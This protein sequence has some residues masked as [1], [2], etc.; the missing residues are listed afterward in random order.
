MQ[1]GAILPKGRRA[2]HSCIPIGTVK[3]PLTQPKLRLSVC[4]KNLDDVVSTSVLQT[5]HERGGV[6]GTTT[7]QIVDGFAQG[8]TL[9]SLTLLG[10]FASQ[11]SAPS[12]HAGDEA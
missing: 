2:L 10:G 1:V 8:F 7:R 5:Q 12:S 9:A 6:A 4:G 11:S 3:H